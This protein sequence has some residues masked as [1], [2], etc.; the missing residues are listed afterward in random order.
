M[1]AKIVSPVRERTGVKRLGNIHLVNH[2]NVLVPKVL[3]CLFQKIL[4][5]LL[6]QSKNLIEQ[7]QPIGINS[8]AENLDSKSSQILHGA[9]LWPLSD[10]P[11]ENDMFDIDKAGLFEVSF[12]LVGNVQTTTSDRGGFGYEARIFGEGKVVCGLVGSVFAV[13]ADTVRFSELEPS[14]RFQVPIELVS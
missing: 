8:R 14:S 6:R 9:L 5:L 1:P 2:M 3:L 10:R 12:K 4:H 13:G 7:N 11:F